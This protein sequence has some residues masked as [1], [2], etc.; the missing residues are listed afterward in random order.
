MDN[1][2]IVREVTEGERVGMILYHYITSP[3]IHKEKV[4]NE[5]KEHK[6]P[7]ADDSVGRPHE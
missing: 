4:I 6:T 3:L 5:I 1:R 2:L 7:P